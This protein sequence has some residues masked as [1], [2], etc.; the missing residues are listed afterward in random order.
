[1]HTAKKFHGVLR[2]STV[3][4]VEKCELSSWAYAIPDWDLFDLS[5]DLKFSVPRF[6]SQ[7]GQC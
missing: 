7:T 3:Q 2:P 6:K 5:E 4:V 1:M